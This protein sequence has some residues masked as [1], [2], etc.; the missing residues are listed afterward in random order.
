M[1]QI[2]DVFPVNHPYLQMSKGENPEVNQMIDY[3]E[4]ALDNTKV[5]KKQ[6]NEKNLFKETFIQGYMYVYDM[7]SMASLEEVEKVIEYIHTRE[8]KEAGKKKSGQVAKILVGTKKDICGYNS[9]IPDSKIDQIKK[10]FAIKHHRKASSLTNDMVSEACLDLARD[11]INRSSGVDG[12]VN[13]DNSDEESNGLFG[14][15]SCGKRE[16]NDSN[17]CRIH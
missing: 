3:Y 1:M 4:R 17:G 9:V 10:K 6:S 15:L 16:K 8:E 11:A 12:Q 14:F 5:D 7:T 2:E 13:S